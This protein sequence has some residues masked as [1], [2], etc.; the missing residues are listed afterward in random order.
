LSNPELVANAGRLW[1]FRVQNLGTWKDYDNELFNENEVALFSIVKKRSPGK[2]NR[3]ETFV[4]TKHRTFG[5]YSFDQKRYATYTELMESLTLGRVATGES[6]RSPNDLTPE[7]LR[8]S[9]SIICLRQD[10][11]NAT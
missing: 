7:E 1:S 8:S 9:Q 10:L 11:T 5:Y 3:Y 6:D 2:R 4:A